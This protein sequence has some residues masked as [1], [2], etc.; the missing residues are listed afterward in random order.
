MKKSTTG[1][2]IIASAI[3]WGAVIFGCALV[4]KG[5]PYKEKIDNILYG[6]VIFHLLFI[7]A[8]LG[9]QLRNKKRGRSEG[10]NLNS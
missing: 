2:L 6:G 4:L 9:N 7:W 8:P 5:T 1:Y 10:H 3:V